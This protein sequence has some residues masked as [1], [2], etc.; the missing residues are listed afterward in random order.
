MSFRVC[1][2]EKIAIRGA[3]AAVSSPPAAWAAI[4]PLPVSAIK[5]SHTHFVAVLSML[6]AKEKPESHLRDMF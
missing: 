3:N 5:Q 2:L 6:A 1:P 4:K